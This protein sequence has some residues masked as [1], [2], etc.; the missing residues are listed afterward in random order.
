MTIKEI[1][2]W[3]DAFAPFSL[4]EEWD[5]AGL[6]IGGMDD[7]VSGVVVSL[8]LTEK[9][10]A[11]AGEAGANLILTHHPAI[12]DP[13][14]Q[15][16]SDS[17]V[18]TCARR[19][20]AVL[21]A[22]TNLDLAPGGVNRCLAERLGFEQCYPLE[23]T[24][25]VPYRT[26]VVFVPVQHRDEVIRAMAAAGAGRL[27]DYAGCAFSNDGRGQFT[28]LEG[29]HA[30]IGEVGKPELVDEARIEM[31]CPADRVAAVVGAMRT[32]HP[33]E[34]PAYGIYENH[35]VADEYGDVLC[36]ALAEPMDPE[37][38][39]TWVKSRLVLDRVRCVLG[40]RPIHRAAFCCGAGGSFFGRAADRGADA[41][42]TG[43]VKHS[44]MVEAAERGITLIDAGH[45]ETERFIVP[46][47][48]ERL[49]GAFPNLPVSVV[50]EGCPYQIL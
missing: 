43:D 40:K 30:F 7:A 34:E 26:V 24:G 33:Y 8:D 36:A 45:Y 21:S 50:E 38:F 14:K 3:L 9:A 22:H 42:I 12:F 11:A 27:G 4:A 23:A 17:L 25:R 5:N 28:P 49:R 37:V 29:A 20:I 1:Y 41:Y 48:A 35:A 18:Y 13:L 15:L 19:G 16:R 32:A 2:G 10:L 46:R 31:L 47:L 6:Q 39:V 44:T